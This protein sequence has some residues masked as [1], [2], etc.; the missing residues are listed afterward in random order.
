MFT[1]FF[2]GNTRVKPP[3]FQGF[4]SRHVPSHPQGLQWSPGAAVVPSRCLQKCLES[5]L[6]SPLQDLLQGLLAEV[7]ALLADDEDRPE[8]MKARLRWDV[9]PGRQGMIMVGV[10]DVRC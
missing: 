7:F 5:A 9:Q 6:H 3:I 8:Q 1:T 10:S 4:S 2:H